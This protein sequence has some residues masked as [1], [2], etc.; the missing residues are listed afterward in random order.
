MRKLL[1]I[2]L[3]TLTLACSKSN[4]DPLKVICLN[5]NY[6]SWLEEKMK[7]LSS[8]E[9]E[10]AFFAGSYKGQTVFEQRLV[11]AICDGI[12]IVYNDKG[13]ELFTT[14]N[15]EEYK[16]YTAEVKN[17]HEIWR[18]SKTTGAQ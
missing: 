16:K 15:N 12:D 1:T 14:M 17:L 4:K 11:S 5:E 2:F 13:K 8:C 7:S 6:P 18:C 9:C 3:L 10:T